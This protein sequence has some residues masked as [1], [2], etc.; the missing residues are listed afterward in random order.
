[1]S[2]YKTFSDKSYMQRVKESERMGKTSIIN[3]HTEKQKYVR[4][5]KIIAFTI[6]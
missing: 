6:F 3:K 1:M 2:V 5:Q 4:W